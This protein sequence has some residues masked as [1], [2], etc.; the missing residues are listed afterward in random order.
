MFLK[1]QQCIYHQQHPWQEQ[2]REQDKQQANAPAVPLSLAE[3][4]IPDRY[5]KQ[6][7]ANISSFLIVVLQLIEY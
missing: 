4:I 7:Q 6:G 3:L 1:Q 2:F 5:S